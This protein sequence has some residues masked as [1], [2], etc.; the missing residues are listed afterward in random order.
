[1]LYFLLL[2]K[3]AGLAVEDVV[4]GVEVW[5]VDFEACK[6]PVP[7][8]VVCDVLRVTKLFCCCGCALDDE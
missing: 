4:V 3:V 5:N 7:A 8:T 1:M 2:N 6:S